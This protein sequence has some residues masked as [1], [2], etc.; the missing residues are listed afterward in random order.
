[1]NAMFKTLFDYFPA[2]PVIVALI[3]FM[4]IP[5]DEA[6]APDENRCYPGHCVTLSEDKR[7]DLREESVSE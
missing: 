1:M 7:G 2:G 3:I 5:F 6:N 4:L